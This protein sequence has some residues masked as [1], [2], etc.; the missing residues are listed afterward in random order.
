M[1]YERMQE[2]EK[3]LTEGIVRLL[4]E[5]EATDVTEGAAHGPKR[6]GDELPEDLA[7]RRI[8]LAML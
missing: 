2:E 8:R 7:Q 5:A 6:S 4:A 1:S 3:W